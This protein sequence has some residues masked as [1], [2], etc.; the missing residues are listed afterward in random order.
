MKKYALILL[1]IVFCVVLSACGSQK[2]DNDSRQQ[3][4]TSGSNTKST[5]SQGWGRDTKLIGDWEGQML[6][7]SLGYSFDPVDGPYTSSSDRDEDVYIRFYEDGNGSL[8]MYDF[9]WTTKGNVVKLSIRK[10]GTMN[11]TYSVSGDKLTLTATNSDGDYSA[12][13][14]F[15]KEKGN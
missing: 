13:R 3:A 4:I 7:T 2:T 9:Q 1:A 5:D 8:A 14:T 10:G 15:T 11:L 12:T 6:H